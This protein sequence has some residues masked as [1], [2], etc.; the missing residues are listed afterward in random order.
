MRSG[1]TT[2]YI[3]MNFTV[4]MGAVTG[5]TFAYLAHGSFFIPEPTRE[6]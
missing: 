2:W 4:L 3:D 1:N 5:P 6:P